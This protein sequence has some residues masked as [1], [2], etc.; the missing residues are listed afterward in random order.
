MRSSINICQGNWVAIGHTIVYY[1]RD[2]HAFGA[3]IKYRHCTY[4]FAL[5]ETSLYAVFHI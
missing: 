4:V 1:A 5:Y 2:A 3:G